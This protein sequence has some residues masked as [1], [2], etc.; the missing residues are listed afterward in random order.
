MFNWYNYRVVRRME[1]KER[2]G[3]VRGRREE[4]RTSGQNL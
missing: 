3:G 2:E 1:E 4:R